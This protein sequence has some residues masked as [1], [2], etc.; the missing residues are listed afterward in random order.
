MSFVR[1]G[2][3]TQPSHETLNLGMSPE[4]VA[5]CVVRAAH[6]LRHACTN[7]AR[8]GRRSQPVQWRSSV[9]PGWLAWAARCHGCEGPLELERVEEPKDPEHG[10]LR[11]GE[12]P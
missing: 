1:V 10:E 9:R 7:E 4:C 2:T 12:D 3:R 8:S 5:K 11:H 6:H